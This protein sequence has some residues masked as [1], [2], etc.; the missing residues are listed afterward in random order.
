MNIERVVKEIKRELI[1]VTDQLGVIDSL[2]LRGSNSY[3]IHEVREILRNWVIGEFRVLERK[4][5]INEFNKIGI[6]HI[7]AM[8]SHLLEIAVEELGGWEKVLRLPI[9]VESV[10]V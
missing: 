5:L 6:N 4:E 7:Y 3:Y 10:S 1:G 2:N 8:S 9:T